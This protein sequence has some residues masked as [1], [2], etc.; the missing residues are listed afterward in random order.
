MWAMDSFCTYNQDDAM[1][2]IKAMGHGVEFAGE[3]SKN[4]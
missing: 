3:E 1:E 4:K 2:K